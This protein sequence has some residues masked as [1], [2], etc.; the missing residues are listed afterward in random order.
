MYKFDKDNFVTQ[1]DY[2]KIEIKRSIIKQWLFKPIFRTL[3]QFLAKVIGIKFLK[4]NKSISKFN[5]YTT[6]KEIITIRNK[7]LSSYLSDF[8]ENR[9]IKIDLQFP[10]LFNFTGYQDTPCAILLSKKV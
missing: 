8:F 1:T 7:K 9:G 5:T 4:T 2:F 3:N 6:N 10:N